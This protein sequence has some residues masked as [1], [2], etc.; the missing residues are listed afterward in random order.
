MIEIDGSYLEGGGQII[1]TAI[2]LSAL[3]NKAVHIFNIRK[4]RDSPGLKPQHL[5]GI[6]AAR[7]MCGAQVE[8][9]NMNSTD[10]AF[11]PEKIRGGKYD[12]D[13]KTAGSVTLVLQTLVPI[14]VYADSPLEI[15]V[16]GGTAVPFSPPIGY[17]LYVLCPLLQIIGVLIHV[18]VKRHG[19]YPR[20]GGELFVRVMPSD[21][22][23]TMMIE[24]GVAKEVKVWIFASHHL[25]AAKVAERI[26][27]GFSKLIKE[28][29]TECFYVDAL[30]PGCFITAC[31]LFEH[32]MLGANALGK[33]GKP[34][35]QVG[36]EAANDLRTAV[37]SNASIDRWMV[38]QL[39]IFMALATQRTGEPS[40]VRIPSLTKHAQ[41]NI[42]VVQKFLQVAFSV[43]NSVL[44]CVRAV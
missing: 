30:S 44:R 4:G 18:E 37:D 12:V 26:Q 10:L 9:L 34:A 2:A 11:I 38:D 7:Q 23:S 43:Q 16:R 29:E 35:E 32:S 24:R 21:L 5:Y 15:T 36:L 33:R 27:T 13:T 8:G 6:S 1:R 22:K 41:T 42:W 3:T 25:N 20:G 17:F 14:G 19:F 39:I 28:A 31:A 40:E